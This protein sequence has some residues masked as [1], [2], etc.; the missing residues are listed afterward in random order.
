[1]ANSK[2]NPDGTV[3]ELGSALVRAVRGRPGCHWM[4]L[5]S[6]RLFLVDILYQSILSVNLFL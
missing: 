4:E 1:M 5:L 3:W 2:E 6:V